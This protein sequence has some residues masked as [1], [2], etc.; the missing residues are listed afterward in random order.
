MWALWDAVLA[1]SPDDFELLDYTCVAVLM[2]IREPLLAARDAPA[3]LGHLTGGV[4]SFG[5]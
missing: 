4:L 1:Q 5:E 3:A 2:A